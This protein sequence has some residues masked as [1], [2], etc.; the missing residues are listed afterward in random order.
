MQTA[1]FDYQRP[2]SLEEAF[3]LLDSE[4]ARPL[5]GGHSL[6]PAMK[7]R[8]SNPTTLVDI[9]RIPGLA[10]IEQG[11][12]EIAIGALT[13][14]EAIA[15]SDVVAGDCTLLAETARHIGDAQVRARGTIGG[16][17]AHADPAADYPPVLLA[18]G[19]TINTASAVGARQ[20][21]ADDFFVDIFTTALQPGE[22]VTSVVVPSIPAGT[23]ATYL[24]HRHPASSYAVVGIAALVMMDGGSITGARLVVG[25]VAGKPIAVDVSSL[26]GQ[27]P[28]AGAFAS[29]VAGVAEALTNPIGDSYASGEY[30]VHLAG[31]LAKRAL[32]A[33]AERAT[34]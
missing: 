17:I 25:G 15:A 4:G 16:S 29:V 34:G 23:G 31:V 3:S 7:L 24:K 10:A 20:I 19:A 26:A 27:A 2:A 22:L 33:A 12:G 9:S 18:L 28:S 5:A 6:L 13:T 14:H 21:G 30:R 11:D 8:V 32:A 1:P